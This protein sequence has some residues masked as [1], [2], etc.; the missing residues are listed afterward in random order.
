MKLA[1][2]LLALNR[3]IAARTERL[4]PY[5]GARAFDEFGP[6]V[7]RCAARQPCEALVDVGAGKD[8]SFLDAFALDE[9]RRVIG[10]DIS[11]DALRANSALNERHVADVIQDGLP[12]GSSSVSMVTSR[13]VLEHLSDVDAF[14]AESARVLVPGGYSVHICS[15]RNAPFAVANRLLPHRVAQRILYALHPEV[16]GTQGFETCY[17][18]CTPEELRAVFTAHGLEVIESRVSYRSAQYFTSLGPLFVFAR[19]YEALLGRLGV[20]RLASY[21][22]IVA[23]KPARPK[24]D[25]RRAT[26]QPRVVYWNYMPAPYMVDRFNALA[27]RGNLNFRAWFSA[28]REPHWSGAWKVDESSWV[29]DH[30][31]V[32]HVFVRGRSVGFPP[33]LLGRRPPEVLISPH[34]EPSFVA[35]WAAARV[36]NVRT[37]FWV[38]RTSDSWFARQRYKEQ[39]KHFMFPRTDAIF[40]PGED[41]R[42][43]AR[44]YGARDEQIIT[45]PHP[46]DAEFAR[47]AARV[48]VEDREK[49]RTE[50]GLEGTTFIYVGRL[51]WGKGLSGLLSA[52]G[53]V[54]R[55]GAD[56]SLLL[57]GDGPERISLLETARQLGL[58]RVVFTGFQQRDDLPRYYSA[59]DVFVFPTLGDPF[60]LVVGEAMSCGLPIIS[61]SAAGEIRTRVEDGRNGFIVAPGDARELAA[62]MRQVDADPA[63]RQKM[64]ALSREK[65]EGRTPE[66]WAADFERGIEHMLDLA[67]GARR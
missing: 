64:G 35:G 11:E 23:R 53:E 38:V 16:V 26:A 67:A 55:E 21:A 22:T 2:R 57:V 43:Y 27:A 1:R 46:V 41:A 42:D 14:V 44:Q 20:E 52:F 13:S 49:L 17:D 3:R 48:R 30:R 54:Q 28:R 25:L 63:L 59:A 58:E 9:S 19:L 12:F 8:S 10:V 37:A 36:R 5:R 56:V 4:W 61:T 29:F 32:P 51:W 40:V 65:V 7:Q 33:D 34:G 31:Y 45:L 50:L 60:G 66:R 6:L 62:R 24:V 39:L 18:R 47:A 15:C